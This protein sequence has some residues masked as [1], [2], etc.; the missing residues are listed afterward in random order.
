MPRPACSPLGA[1]CGGRAKR[2]YKQQGWAKRGYRSDDDDDDDDYDDDNDG[3]DD[4][5]DDDD[6]DGDG[7]AS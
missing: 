1:L 4:G 3:D 5:D 6:A 2:R 7:D